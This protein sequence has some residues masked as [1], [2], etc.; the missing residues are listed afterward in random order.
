MSAL[1]RG[2][3]SPRWS[4]S[5]HTTR[6][7]ADVHR[8]PERS[9][10]VSRTC[11]HRVCLVL[12]GELDRIHAV[13]RCAQTIESKYETDNCELILSHVSWSHI[14]WDF[15][16][17]LSTFFTGS[18]PLLHFPLLQCPPLPHRADLSTPTNSIPATWCRIVHSRT[19]HS[20][21][22]SVPV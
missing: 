16:L 3:L 2:H 7:N 13:W 20:R 6:R 21:K 1:Q 5:P 11:L 9:N 12:N 8:G 22:F 18:W 15:Q 10:V 19:V 14:Q 17:V 4:P